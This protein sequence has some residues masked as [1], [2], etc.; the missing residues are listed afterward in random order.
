MAKLLKTPSF[1]SEEDEF[2]E[3]ANF[4]KRDDTVVATASDG[5]QYTAQIVYVNRNKKTFTVRYKD[6]S[7]ERLKAADIRPF[8]PEDEAEDE[9]ER[10]SSPQSHLPTNSAEQFFRSLAELTKHEPKRKLH[11]QESERP[12]KIQ[13]IHSD[14]LPEVKQAVFPFR[15]REKLSRSL[16]DIPQNE[17]FLRLLVGA[18]YAGA[19]GNF[20]EKIWPIRKRILLFPG[21]PDYSKEA[22]QSI[23]SGPTVDP[24][25]LCAICKLLGISDSS[26]PEATASDEQEYREKT[27]QKIVAFLLR[28][29]AFQNSDEPIW[30][31]QEPETGICRPFSGTI[32]KALEL[33]R[34]QGKTRMLRSIDCQS[35]V[36]NLSRMEVRWL[37]QT[38]PPVSGLFR[39]DPR[40]LSETKLH[41]DTYE[42]EL[43][44]LEEPN[45]AAC[46]SMPSDDLTDTYSV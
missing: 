9:E 45:R 17:P 18:M 46:S 1:A 13:S 21:L 26:G 11:D 19:R 20:D 25:E 40:P 22:A 37:S 14:P 31:S 29:L 28:P 5:L 7:E 43:P 4:F 3:A 8:T 6:G 41:V 10:C 30:F 34:R 44:C 27:A 35:V 32:C 39:I 12:A 33:A 36:F 15:L 24:L 23:L 2:N 38:Q 42:Y 16:K